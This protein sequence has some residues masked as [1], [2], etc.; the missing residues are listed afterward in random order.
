MKAVRKFGRA[1]S[2]QALLETAI[3]A[4]ALCFLLV[5]AIDLGRFSQ[6]DTRLASAARA[7]TQYGSQNLVTAADTAGM[8]TAA[9]NDAPGAGFSAVASHYCTCAGS[10]T[11]VS[12]TAGACSSSHRLLYVSVTVTGTFKPIFSFFSGEAGSHSR[13]AT[14][15]VGQ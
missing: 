5:G 6:F 11:Q 3:V 2:G 10:S 1:E 7:G 12:C 14:V 13:T 9:T 4:P 15:E 8:E